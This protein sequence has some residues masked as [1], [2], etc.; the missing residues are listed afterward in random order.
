M[1]IGAFGTT[2]AGKWRVAHVGFS[3]LRP[4]N[5][6]QERNVPDGLEISA[7]LSPIVNSMCEDS[8]LV[9]LY[10]TIVVAGCMRRQN[11]LYFYSC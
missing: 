8:F 5:F 2:L 9:S 4:V 11:Y 7:Y 6:Y 10:W 3:F 1:L